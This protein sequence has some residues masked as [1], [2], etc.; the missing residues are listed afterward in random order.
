MSHNSIE[1]LKKLTSS[2]YNRYKNYPKIN[3]QRM[4]EHVKPKEIDK[5]SNI[6]GIDIK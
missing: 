5:P 2:P 3:I 4:L 1:F 6:E